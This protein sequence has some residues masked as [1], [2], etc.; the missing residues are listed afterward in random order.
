MT[1]SREF[2]DRL[3]GPKSSGLV[4]KDETADID[5]AALHQEVARCADLLGANGVG[6]GDS[7][8][9]QCE[10]CATLFAL[11]LAT[12][13]LDAAVMLLD[14]R[15]T[16]AE[17]ARLTR[18][19]APAYRVSASSAV[20]RF[21]DRC[22]VRVQ[23]LANPAALPDRVCIV[24]FTSGSTGQA[25]VVGRSAASLDA[26]IDRYGSV[27]DMPTSADRLLLLC[28]PVHT[29]GLF[30]GICYGLAAGMPVLFASAQHGGAIAG[31][32][33]RLDATAIFG[34]PTHFELLAD[35]AR[36]PSLPRL[37]IA[38]SAGMI[39][40][41]QAADRFL[42]QI[43]LPLGQV[44][45]MTE[46]GVVTADLT[47]RYRPPSVG[48]PAPGIELRVSDGELQIRL[49]RSPYL[50]DDGVDRFAD[51]WLRT[52]DRAELSAETGVVHI[53][54]RADSVIT[55]GGIKIDL[56]EIEQVIQEHPDV[57]RVVVTSGAAIEAHVAASAGLTDADL[58]AWCRERLSPVKI[59][60]RLY[61]RDKLPQT[62]T[63]K[64][65]RDREQLLADFAATSRHA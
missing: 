15:L 64:G 30:G 20:A 59:P 13:R 40:T 56:M 16:S 37:R 62:P 10:P 3:I 36:P 12:W 6:A 58:I 26:E 47:G 60:K 42:R 49:D 34:V 54:G 57:R 9:L 61:L 53:L 17:T 8:A 33:S 50:T 23:R 63:G 65:I 1:G 46:V 18:L 22:D 28:S 25:K 51:G 24:Q 31:A 39:T 52:F 35:V 14:Y 55:I 2:S 7:V 45:G 29:W 27:E 19:C 21:T 5:R 48:R 4:W 32:A 44:Y 38:T 11:M 43:G 41:G